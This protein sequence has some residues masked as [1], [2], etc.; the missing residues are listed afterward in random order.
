MKLKKEWKM[1]TMILMIILLILII[2]KFNSNHKKETFIEQNNVI[3]DSNQY[4]ELK[5]EIAIFANVSEDRIDGL[6]IE[7]VLPDVTVSYYILPRTIDNVED[8]TLE[9]VKADLNDRKDTALEFTIDGQSLTFSGILLDALEK[10]EQTKYD[11]LM[12]KFKDKEL[13]KQIQYVKDL[14]NVIK[15]N[16]PMDRFY[17]FSKLGNIVLEKQNDIPVEG[18][19]G[20]LEN[21][22]PP[23]E[24]PIN[25]VPLI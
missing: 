14:K 20:S 6:K 25:Q 2:Y 3:S 22:T 24:R 1:I 15:Y 8:R 23:I 10:S 21:D 9:E 16:N 12:D 7:G 13:D 18:Q 19:E 17:K 5:K 4:I 11:K